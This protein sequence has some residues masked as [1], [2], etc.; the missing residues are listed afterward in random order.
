MEPGRRVVTPSAKPVGFSP[1]LATWIA[2]GLAQCHRSLG[3][4]EAFGLAVRLVRYVM[5]DS[6]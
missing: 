4:E 5:R 2:Q 3:E 1:A 6:G